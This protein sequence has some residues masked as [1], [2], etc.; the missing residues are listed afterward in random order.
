M[1][2]ACGAN[3]TLGLIRVGKAFINSIQ[4]SGRGLWLQD[5]LQTANLL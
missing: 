5:K 2:V 4:S 3:H 1:Q